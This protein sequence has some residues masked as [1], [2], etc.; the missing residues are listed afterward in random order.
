MST[1]N[2]TKR[3]WPIGD[4]AAV[5]F[6]LGGLVALPPTKEAIAAENEDPTEVI[7]SPFGIGSC[8]T[9]NRS[10]EDNAR[11]MPQMTAIGL[12]SYRGPNA[13]WGTVEPEPG[14]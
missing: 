13:G 7:R 8:Y 9:N 11:W 1:A 12:R 3:I 6:A 14:K 5:L 10:A 4:M 2:P